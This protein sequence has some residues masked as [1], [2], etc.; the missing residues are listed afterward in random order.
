MKGKNYKS[1]NC[2]TNNKY[3]ITILLKL[4]HQQILLSH[5]K[6]LS[7]FAFNNIKKQKQNNIVNKQ[8]ISKAKKKL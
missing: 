5:H 7:R 4:V 1:K 8:K 2:Y 3:C 6:I